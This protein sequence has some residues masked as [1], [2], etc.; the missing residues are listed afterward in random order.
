MARSTLLGLAEKGLRN[1]GFAA[2]RATLSVDDI[3]AN[4]TTAW[5][6]DS[7][8]LNLWL[9][10]SKRCCMIPRLTFQER[11]GDASHVMSYS[12]AGGKIFNLVLTHPEK[13]DPSAWTHED[14]LEKMKAQYIGWDPT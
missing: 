3:K 13:A 14:H 2:Y 10:Q 4:E 11:V 5:I 8:S 9:V 12:I 1:H 6:V 7:P